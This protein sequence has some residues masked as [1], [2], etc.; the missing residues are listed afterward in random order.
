LMTFASDLTYY[1][2][3][4]A[5]ANFYIE[6][7]RLDEACRYIQIPLP[8]IKEEGI[9]FLQKMKRKDSKYADDFIERRFVSDV[10]YLQARL[11][12]PD[13]KELNEPDPDKQVQMA[14]MRFRKFIETI[15]LWQK[16]LDGMKVDV[17]YKSST[18]RIEYVKAFSELVKYAAQIRPNGVLDEF[19]AKYRG[20]DVRSIQNPNIPHYID[21][22]FRYCIRPD[23]KSAAGLAVE[24][25]AEERFEGLCKSIVDYFNN[26]IG[27]ASKDNKTS[28]TKVNLDTEHLVKA[29]AALGYKFECTPVLTRV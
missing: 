23:E 17:A 11:E 2:Y 14:R 12:Q 13:E 8:L 3:Q 7:D 4:I 27:V 9:D 22:S 24:G 6:V 19:L 1:P 25:D 5:L 29:M 20:T 26:E 16:Q 18:L 10:S 21:F 15:D 28:V